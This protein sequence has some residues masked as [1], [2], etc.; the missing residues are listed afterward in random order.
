[1]EVG[2]IESHLMRTEK[3]QRQVMKPVTSQKHDAS[4]KKFSESAQGG[5][6]SHF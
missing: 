5:S 2:G 6:S 4:T 1:M 3:E